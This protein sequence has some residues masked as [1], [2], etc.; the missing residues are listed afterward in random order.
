MQRFTTNP[1][2]Y[3]EAS[4]VKKM[5]EMGIGRPSTYAPT[6]STI[7]T[8]EY[9]IKEDRPGK[10]RNLNGLVLSE[11]VIK[12]TKKSEKTGYEK[13][14]LFPTDIGM[15]V[16]DFL[17]DHFGNIM[18]YNFTASVEKDFDRI[19][20]GN[21]I[22]HK[23]IDRFYKPFHNQVDQT[24]RTTHRSSGERILGNHPETGEPVVVK[25][26]RFGPMAQ[27]GE[28]GEDK[29][30]RF[31]RLQKGQLIETITIEEALELFKLP[32]SLG[33]Y[34]G[35]E[36]L[37]GVGKFGPYIRYK[38]SFYSMK[39]GQ[40]DPM[41]VSVERAIEII[42][43]KKEADTRKTIKGF[44]NDPDLLVL[45][46]RYGPYISYKKTNYRI[47]KSLDPGALSYEECQEIIEKAVKNKKKK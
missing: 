27:I 6:I 16:N 37:V 10:T 12:P 35:S 31:A 30:P 29:K 17:V 9:V 21:M 14:K 18:D 2:R 33:E 40:D 28:G 45:N 22:W 13:A 1:P 8:R 24:Q 4:L 34:E 32:R 36:M 5:E 39:K 43:Q 19:A 46:G 42:E 7:Q 15:V 20:D 44:E 11:K 41:T 26:G 23:M 25:I 38:G 47:P 3:T